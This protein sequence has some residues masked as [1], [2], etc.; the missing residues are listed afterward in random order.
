MPVLNVRDNLLLPLR[1]AHRK[2]DCGHFDEVV[3]TL[4]LGGRP[5]HPPHELS[6]GAAPA[7]GHRASGAR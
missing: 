1:L 7:R 2:V 6:G 4:G 5:R 3:E